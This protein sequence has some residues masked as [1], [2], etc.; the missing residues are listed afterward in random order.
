MN[1]NKL[2]L[3]VLTIL[4]SALILSACGTKD[5]AVATAK[6][7]VQSAEIV[8][9]SFEVDGMYCASCPFVV[10]SAIKRIDGVKQAKVKAEGPSGTVNVQ[11]DKNKTDLASIQQSV[12]DLGYEVQ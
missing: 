1:K 7:S 5:T 10:E 12:L 11:F 8:S 4:S 2:L 9:A 6:E 3:F